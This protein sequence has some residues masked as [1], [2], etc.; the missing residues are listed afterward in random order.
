MLLFEF[1]VLQQGESDSLVYEKYE[2]IHENQE[3]IDE[4]QLV[5]KGVH[6]FFCLFYLLLL[7]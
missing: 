6:F 3:T 4:L 1:L 2:F 5:H 7:I